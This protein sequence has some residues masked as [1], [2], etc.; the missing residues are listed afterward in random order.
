MLR[1]QLR[2]SSATCRLPLT[3]S[4][5][6]ISSRHAATA[7]RPPPPAEYVYDGGRPQLYSLPT[8]PPMPP[9]L[10]VDVEPTATRRDTRY[11]VA[12]EPGVTLAHHAPAA[13]EQLAIL[14]VCLSTGN[15]K[16]AEEI[17]KRIVVAWKRAGEA[18]QLS[19]VLS[20]RIHADFIKAYLGRAMQPGVT[21]AEAK[22]AVH[23]TWTYFDHL[24][25]PQWNVVDPITQRKHGVSGA[26]DATVI[27]TML[28][29]FT[30]LGPAFYNP[31]PE[32]DPER[33]L[34]PIT[35]ILPLMPK[36]GVELDEVL[37]DPIFAL[38]APIYFGSVTRSAAVNAL[39]ETGEG[40]S[41]WSR[42]KDLVAHAA[43]EVK[44]FEEGRDAEVP[45][46]KENVAEVAPV[47]GDK[48]ENVSLGMLK[49][50][51]R[52]LAVNTG[53]DGLPLSARQRLLEE[54]SYDA[55]RQLYIHSR[56]QL[57]QIGKDEGGLQSNW[58]QQIMFDWHKKLV[59]TLEDIA[60]GKRKDID[61]GFRDRELEPFLQLLPVDKLALIT[62]VEVMR[63]CGSGT[64]AAD[65]M[66]TTRVVLNVGRAVENEHHA[67]ALRDS[68]STKKLQEELAKVESRGTINPDGTV[69][70]RRQTESL[71]ILW[72]RELAKREEDGDSTWHPNWTQ[73]I[74]ARVGSVLVSALMEIAEVE[75]TIKHPKTGEQVSEKQPAFSH[76]YQ[77]MRG[78]KLGII[79][80]NPAVSERLDKDPLDIT[81]HPRF[82]PMLVKP[83]PWL[84]WNSGAYLLHQTPMM[85]TKESEEQVQYL[86]QASDNHTL[87]IIFSGLDTLGAVPWKINRKVFDTVVQV[88]NSGDAFADIPAAAQ[89]LE[90][91]TL[92]IPKGVMS[93]PRARDN[94]R[95]RVRELM[96]QKRAAHSMRCDLNYKL[97][98]ARAF[99]GET[100]YFPHNLD[101]RGRAYPIP[102]NL[103]HI[104]DDMSRGLL[105]FA[106]SKPLG[107][108]GLRWL[109]IHVSNLMGF[110]KASFDEREAFTMEHLEDVF[111]SADNPL[112]GRKWW[113]KADDPWQCL[114]TCI[115][116]T[117]ALRSEDPTKYECGLPIHQDGTCNGLQHY[118]ALGGDINGARQVNLDIGDRPADV[119]SGV[120][121]MVQEI[122]T[123]DV[124]AGVEEAKLLDGKITRKVVKQTVMTTVYGVTFIGAKNQIERQLKDRGDVP[125]ERLYKCSIYLGRLVLDSIGDLFKG[126]AAIQTW[127][128]RCARLIAKSIP[129]QRIEAALKQEKPGKNKSK[130]ALALSRIPK[131]QMTS[132]VWTT[133]LGLPVCQPY[134]RP[135]KK[136]V[137]TALQTVHIWDPSIPAEVDPRAQATA[138]PPNFI[139]SLDATHM[140]MTALAC[141]GKIAFAS[142][143]DS[144][145]TH[146]CD[147][148]EMSTIL[149]DTFIDL[150]SQDILGRLRDEFIH[151]YA[152]HV[153]P[154]SKIPPGLRA[155]TAAEAIKEAEAPPKQV[156]SQAAS[157]L[158]E[159]LEQEDG[160]EELT[161]FNRPK[162]ERA[163]SKKATKKADAESGEGAA[164]AEVVESQAPQ[165]MAIGKLFAATVDSKIVYLR[166][167]LPYPPG[168]GDFDLER[169]RD[170]PYFFN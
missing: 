128:N 2:L 72:R 24:F 84:T 123:R 58:I 3:P 101:F 162:V 108:R 120:A 150:H 110:D 4:L 118:A 109:K 69:T 62:I 42:F 160:V 8:L 25:E 54:S 133:P 156:D 103:S 45:A 18:G 30:A 32:S 85:R 142:V 35:A 149:R 147:V 141:K 39:I 7:V 38:D 34:R 37:R 124:E 168:K 169:V 143:H 94:Y 125:A 73:T 68:L 21:P 61:S 5:T 36:A 88:W 164:E 98:I 121:Q 163:K 130:K 31:S 41:G 26:V 89:K 59:K 1:T 126:A 139:H 158:L 127:L 75:R 152:G 91:P 53:R 46:E 112:E 161:L 87:D 132:V 154:V 29:G 56:E 64:F 97:E 137:Q 122:I 10:P 170:S 111:D 117:N 96:Q 43:A 20:P 90:I 129:P 14:G 17:A 19:N 33:I 136:Q 166:D 115:E 86:Q 66:K 13:Q 63:M 55:A 106:E 9:P 81:L 6:R 80:L 165:D 92:E 47:Q 11:G 107:E 16:R 102:P 144:Y 155:A 157:K 99:L 23:R 140:M 167:V 74:R 52:G 135:K 104:G 57:A 28:K 67:E 15:L 113:T 95:R 22:D 83:K 65:G 70:P 76:A 44:R 71:G 138:F 12:V 40:R 146:A 114:A 93:D 100:F 119:Y 48:G 60:A 82:L 145:W 77:Y 131:E 148:D 159:E 50:N 116:L 49:H 134:R 153:V 78:T 151:R 105:L 51:L 27:A 79:K